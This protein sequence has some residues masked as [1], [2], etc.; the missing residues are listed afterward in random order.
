MREVQRK[1][2]LAEAQVGFLFYAAT[3][4]PY[5]PRLF[6]FN[7]ILDFMPLLFHATASGHQLAYRHQSGSTPG[8]LFCCGFRSDLSSTKATA[9]AEWCK[10]EGVSFTCF[11]YY[12]HGKSGG[13]FS[14]FTIGQAISDTI[15]M[16]DLLGDPQILIGSSM[17]AWAALHAALARK[18]Q[19]RALIG[20]AA[21]PDFTERLMF[22]NMTPEQRKEVEEEGKIWVHSDYTE[23]DYPITRNLIYEAR[24]HLLLDDVIGLDI[25]V[26]LFHGQQDADVPWENSLLLARQL[27]SEDV[28][29]SFI[30][31]GDH[32]LNRPS[33]LALLMDAVGRM[34]ALCQ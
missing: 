34:H 25:P 30:K 9:L 3:I 16:L 5:Y 22:A 4:A 27:I 29:T 7:A 28:V 1:T 14:D 18:R 2:T 13:D 20:V 33:D 17:G 10:A 31:D 19:V 23:S 8:I 11:D 32:R 26:Q 6:T 15:E 12:G 24:T 21:A